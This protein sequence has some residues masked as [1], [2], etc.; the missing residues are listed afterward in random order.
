MMFSPSTSTKYQAQF[1]PLEKQINQQKSCVSKPFIPSAVTPAGH[2]EEPRSFEAVLNWQTQNAV[3]HNQA[4]TTLHYKVDNITHKT[5]QIEK[6][7]D[8]ISDKLN[9][10]Y[11]N[12]Y[13][14]VTQLDSELRA[15]IA[16]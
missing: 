2:L 7:V 14:R 8:T 10:I 9:H 3:A 13:N 15:M 6:K 16:Q 12:L 5:N 11:Q 1:L 4:L